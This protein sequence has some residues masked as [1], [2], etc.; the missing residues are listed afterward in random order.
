MWKG[1]PVPWCDGAVAIEVIMQASQPTPELGLI[2]SVWAVRVHLD[3]MIIPA[4]FTT[5][6][7]ELA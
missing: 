4:V 7:M 5:V 6:H 3:A 1:K 2:C